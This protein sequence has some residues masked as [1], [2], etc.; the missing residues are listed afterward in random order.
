MESDIDKGI[1]SFR[2][3][4]IDNKTRNFKVKGLNQFVNN[5]LYNWGEGA[6]YNM[7]GNSEGDSET[8]IEDNYFIV[9]RGNMWRN[10]LVSTDPDGTKNYEFQ[11]IQVTPAKP[12][13]DGNSNFKTYLSGNYYDTNKNG[14]LDGHLLLQE[15]WSGDPTI[16]STPSILHPSIKSQT[17]ATDAYKYI[18]E[19]VG[20]YLPTRDEVDTYLIEELTSLGTKGTIIGRPFSVTQF[21]IGGAVTSKLVLLKPIRTVMV[22]LMNSRTN[23]DWIRTKP[24]M[25]SKLQR[26][27]I[28]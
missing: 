21:P 7:S 10:A 4:L 24:K 19:K 6:A 9:G 22:C 8:T 18:V 23:G 17:N 25:R 20:A 27:A 3:L 11:Y 5:V 15:E 12:F 16:L 1:T 13:K 28:R 26:T 14:V 2:N